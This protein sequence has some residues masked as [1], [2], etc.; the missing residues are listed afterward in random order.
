MNP[1]FCGPGS[2][3]TG[4]NGMVYGPNYSVVPPYLPFNGLLP[5]PQLRNDLPP[6]GAG[7]PAGFVSFPYAR[8]P[9]DY[10][11]YEENRP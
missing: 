3:Y 8:S 9:R 6:A 7:G 1:D 5:M 11:I 4:P 10:F 2:Y